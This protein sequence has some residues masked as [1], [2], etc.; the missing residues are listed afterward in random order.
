MR[1]DDGQHRKGEGNVRG[2]GNGPAFERF[3]GSSEV[4]ENVD[5]GRH[6]H[7]ANGCGDGDNC[8]GWFSEF[9]RNEFTL[10]FKPSEE[11]EHRQQAI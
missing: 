7:S 11:E 8:A 4:E 1:V 3:S 5:Q 6:H 10:K 9:A 2:C